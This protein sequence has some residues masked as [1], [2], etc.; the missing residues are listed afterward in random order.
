M[1]RKCD[2]C[3]LCCTITRVPE[4]NKAEY[5]SCPF[6]H[7]KNSGCKGCSIYKDRPDSCRKY[8]CAWLKGDMPDWMKPDECHLMIEKIPNAP[9]VLALPEPGYEN[10]WRT[11]KIEEV[12]K[13]EYQE[14]GIAVVAID[15]MALLPKGMTPQEAW[16]HVLD[17][18]RMIMGI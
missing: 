16:K 3:T 6:L 4:I 11:P 14:K 1:E 10:N 5:T 7:E 15:K 12:L 17:Y 2:G 9:V 13:K 8:E 18:S